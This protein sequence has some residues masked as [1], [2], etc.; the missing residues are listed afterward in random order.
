MRLGKLPNYQEPY[1]SDS[2]DNNS[3]GEKLLTIRSEE[4]NDAEGLSLVKQ[5]SDSQGQYQDSTYQPDLKNT[6]NP[7]FQAHRRDSRECNG[8]L[9]SVAGSIDDHHRF[10]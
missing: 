7:G 1:H 2:R 9:S 6:P 8:I 5:V 10:S 4:S 3:K